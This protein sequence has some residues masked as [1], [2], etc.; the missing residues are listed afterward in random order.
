MSDSSLDRREFLSTGLGLA[1]ALGPGAA[2]RPRRQRPH[3]PRGHRLRIARQLHPQ[4]GDGRRRGSDRRGRDRRRLVG[5]PRKDG[6]RRRHEVREAAAE[7][8]RALRRPARDAG[9][10]CRDH[11]HAR[12]RAL[13][14]A[15]GR[16]EGRQGRVR[17]EAA[18]RP[19]RRRGGG[20]RRRQGQLEDRPGRHA[21]PE[22]PALQGRGRVRAVG[23]AR[24]RSARSRRRGTGTCRAGAGRSTTA[25]RRTWTGSSS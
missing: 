7:A 11:H 25:R 8:V 21:A 4:R 17:R 9:P 20:L 23:C 3:Q 13:R 5:Q 6:R 15:H 24:A 16:G 19:P 2:R 14:G 18:L 12:L 22:Q 10:R 1:A